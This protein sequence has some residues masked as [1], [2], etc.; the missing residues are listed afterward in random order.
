MLMEENIERRIKMS[1]DSLPNSICGLPLEQRLTQ[2]R[3]KVINLDKNIKDCGNIRLKTSLIY[4]KHNAIKAYKKLKRE[5]E[6]D[7]YGVW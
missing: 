3:M 6:E 4:R 7:R 5:M 1:D 2:A